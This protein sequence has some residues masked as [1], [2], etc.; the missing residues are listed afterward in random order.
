M[1][2]T[3]T[4]VFSVDGRKI[5]LSVSTLIVRRSALC[6]QIPPL[7]MAPVNVNINLANGA[8][9]EVNTYTRQCGF[10]FP[11]CLSQLLHSD[12]SSVCFR[13]VFVF[14][15]LFLSCS[16]E[17][18]SSFLH[19]SLKHN[20]AGYDQSL[21]Q[22]GAQNCVFPSENISFHSYAAGKKRGKNRAQS[23]PNNIMFMTKKNPYSLVHSMFNFIF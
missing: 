5:A 4:T 15:L 14:W 8:I 11:V 12:D 21:D 13:A 16:S 18:S 10:I 19:F 22:P 2:F 3:A 7:I 20:E 23:Q 1:F 6:A 9:A 17:D